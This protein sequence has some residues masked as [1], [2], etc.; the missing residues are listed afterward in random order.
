MYF[1]RADATPTRHQ[2]DQNS[3]VR[4]QTAVDRR[5]NCGELFLRPRNLTFRH[6]SHKEQ[7]DTSPAFDGAHFGTSSIIYC[8]TVGNSSFYRVFIRAFIMLMLCKRGSRHFFL[9]DAETLLRNLIIACL[10]SA[11]GTLLPKTS[12]IFY[13]LFT[14]RYEAR[15]K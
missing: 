3:S 13:L 4:N 14:L 1:T 12:L 5:E 7:G 9:F 10:R 15:G 6:R 2:Y 8:L 11:T